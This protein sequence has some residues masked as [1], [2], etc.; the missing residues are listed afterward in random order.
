MQDPLW[1]RISIV[2]ACLSI[3]LILSLYAKYSDNSKT[4]KPQTH[5][6]TP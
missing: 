5:S 2:S 6:H 1:L 3:V 4:S